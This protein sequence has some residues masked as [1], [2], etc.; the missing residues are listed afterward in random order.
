VGAASSEIISNSTKERIWSVTERRKF[1][2]ER[3]F[4][5][6]K[7]RTAQKRFTEMAKSFSS[8]Q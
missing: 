4:S 8:N 2:M 7:A 3:R 6:K 5:H 1:V